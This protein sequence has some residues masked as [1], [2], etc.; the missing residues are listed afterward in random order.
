[1]SQLTRIVFRSCGLT[2]G[3]NMAPPP[4]GPRTLKLPGRGA[5]P[6]PLARRK[7]PRSPRRKKSAISFLCFPYHLFR[8]LSWQN[9]LALSILFVSF[10]LK[11]T[12]NFDLQEPGSILVVD[13]LKNL[14]RQ[15]QAIN[16][17]APLRRHPRRG[18]IEILVFGF[19]K[20]VIDFVQL[21]GEDLLRRV[22]PVRNGVGSK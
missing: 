6:L 4:P 22:R 21:V 3:W 15:S 1:M 16:P 17:P 8:F 2:V 19:Q 7:N 20:P 12:L 18:V 13:L 14:I 5:S 11:D 9:P 10:L